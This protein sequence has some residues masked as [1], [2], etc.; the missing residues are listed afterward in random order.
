MKFP[1]HL[2]AIIILILSLASCG[3]KAPVNEPKT[4][5]ELGGYPSA[6]EYKG[7]YYY[8]MQR[9][10]QAKPDI[11]LFAT[12]DITD[13]A[14]GDSVVVWSP[15][16]LSM[17]NFWSPEV[18]RI[19]NKW[20]IYFEADNGQSTD[21]HQIY[22]LE[23]P[24]DDP[25]KGKWQ[26]RGPIITNE[27]WNF[28]IHPST[29]TVNG[30]QYLLWSGWQRRR[31]EIETQCIFIAEMANPWTLKSERV[32]LSTPEFEWERQWI[33]PDGSR[34]AY[35]IFVNE[36]PEAFLSPDGKRVFVVYSASGIWTLYNTLGMLYAST[37]SDLLNPAS[38]TKVRD[39]QFVADEESGL[40]GA[41]N[42]SLV[43][44]PDKSTYVLYQVKT[45]R[46]N[47]TLSHIRVK[48]IT[49]SA[50]GMPEFGKP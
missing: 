32:L 48:P 39:P 25:M 31:T 13:F 23:N 28:G 35:P 12:K 36:N 3:D 20:Y 45:M 49:W 29:F 2:Q 30:R 43:Y 8:T 34:S 26:L 46:N 11:M 33:N 38:W 22:V 17:H 4:V 10:S 27:E 9:E 24:S 1:L 16:E 44:A 37:D 41:S 47:F 40:F 15:G 14:G 50:T 18:H 6:T 19:N 7:T 42:I 5:F 21:N